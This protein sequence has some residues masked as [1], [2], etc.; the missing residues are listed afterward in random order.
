MTEPKTRVSQV[1]VNIPHL[2]SGS[3]GV[4][5]ERRENGKISIRNSDPDNVLVECS[6]F[7]MSKDRPSSWRRVART[8]NTVRDN[9]R[10]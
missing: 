10:T 5:I 4:L 3:F 1:V 8:S 9:L 7:E 6:D 2:D